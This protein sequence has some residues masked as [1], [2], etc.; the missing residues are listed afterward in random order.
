MNVLKLISFCKREGTHKTPGIQQCEAKI[1]P[2]LCL[3][4]LKWGSLCCWCQ[5]CWRW[6]QS[7]LASTP[8]FQSWPRVCRLG[9]K[10]GT[11]S[12]A[13]TKKWT[14]KSEDRAG[15]ATEEKLSHSTGLLCSL[16]TE[17]IWQASRSL[18]DVHNATKDITL[19]HKWPSLKEY[20][21][22]QTPIFA[23]LKTSKSFYK[24]TFAE[25]YQWLQFMSCCP[26]F[27]HKPFRII[28]RCISEVL[29][30]WSGYLIKQYWAVIT[31]RLLSARACNRFL[32]QLA[33]N[34]SY[35]AWSWRLCSLNCNV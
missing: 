10:L 25:L 23:I 8:T 15:F 21:P 12:T 19:M 5:F 9:L 20:F 24:A 2:P 29:W 7:C 35:S 11:S 17:S 16:S 4:Y 13:K 18:A 1:G 14:G 6:K 3:H 31:C 26:W 22:H 32:A 30:L 28:H 34:F 27:C 33:M